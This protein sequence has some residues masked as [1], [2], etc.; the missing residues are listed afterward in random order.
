M[1]RFTRAAS[2]TPIVDISIREKHHRWRIERSQIEAYALGSALNVNRGWWEHI[3]I[4]SRSLDV[5]VL[6][7]GATVT[8][9]ICEDLARS[10]PCQE[11][12]RGI[13]PN[14]VV[15]LLMDG[16]QIRSRWPA[17]YGTVL[18]DDPGSSV[19]TVT[20]L[21]LIQR[22]NETGAF[23]P[24]N[25]IGLFQD[26]TGKMTEIQMP[27]WAQAMCLTLQP[28]KL[29]ERTLDGRLDDGS[30]QSWRLSAIVP[31]ALA[32]HQINQDILAGRWS[33]S[34]D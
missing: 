23:A 34:E 24:A 33:K 12:V 29:H 17:R 8:T 30:A 4:L 28:T 5:L 21:G 25:Q 11:L 13:G 1:A 26:D 3:D 19:L 32:H 22:S 9:L 18:A 7:G 31:V 16:P 15:A 10:D 20:S 6:R 27:S 14:F 2:G